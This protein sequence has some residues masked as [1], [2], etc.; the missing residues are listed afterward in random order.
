MSV[1]VDFA[2]LPYGTMKMC[3]MWA[4]TA[5]ELHAMADAIGLKRRW[6]QCPSGPGVKRVS[7]P[8]YD[9]GAGKRAKAV[10]LGA[11]EVSDRAEA[12]NHRRSVRARMIDDFEFAKTW[13]YAV[14]IAGAPR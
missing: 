5:E 9:V 4:D 11:I 8:H 6:Y 3:H 13:G 12:V 1:Y 14:A 10:E 7:F 2:Y